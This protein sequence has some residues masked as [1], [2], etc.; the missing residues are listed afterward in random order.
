LTC[1]RV[2]ISKK[3]RGVKKPLFLFYLIWAFLASKLLVLVLGKQFK[4]D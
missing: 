1:F 3:E 4:A 2:D